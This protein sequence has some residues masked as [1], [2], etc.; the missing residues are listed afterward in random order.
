MLQQL[1][2]LDRRFATFRTR[3]CL[4][5][6]RSDGFY[7]VPL[8]IHIQQHIYE[9]NMTFQREWKNLTDEEKELR[10]L[11]I[12]SKVIR[13]RM[14]INPMNS[15][16]LCGYRRLHII[17]DVNLLFRLTADLA[18]LPKKPINLGR[19]IEDWERRIRIRIIIGIATS[20][21]RTSNKSI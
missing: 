1:E 7:Y 12:R 4:S 6:I 21:C 2:S 19:N 16:P 14:R 13:K 11:D 15:L 9:N 18:Q 5:D 17:F 3:G 10:T 20:K 8:F